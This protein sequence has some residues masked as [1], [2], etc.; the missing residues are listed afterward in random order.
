MRRKLR[1]ALRRL[2]TMANLFENLVEV[3][4]D[5][6]VLSLG[7]SLDYRLFPS[8]ILT[9]RDCVLFTNLAAEALIRELD[10]KKGERALTIIPN[11]GEF[12]LLSMAV[13]KA[14]GIIVP[15]DH[16]LP[17]DE[18]RRRA[19]GCWAGLAVIDGRVLAE[20]PD[21]AESMPAVERLMVSGPRRQAPGGFPS[22]DEAMG[23]SSGFFIP[24][25]LKPG[26]V[27]GLFYSSGRN[28][29]PRAVMATNEMLLG[30]RRT[31]GL[32]LPAGPGDRC[33]CALPPTSLPGF[34][35]AV[36]G[37]C[38]GLRFYLLPDGD[39]ERILRALQES[40]P[41][42]F[43]ASPVLY[44]GMLEAGADGYDLSPVRLWFGAGG[45]VHPGDIDAFRRLGSL[46]LGP[47]RLPAVFAEA[48]GVE[49][50]APMAA[51][52]LALSGAVRTA[53]RPCF[54]LPPNRM[55][56]VDETGRGVQ[57]GEEGELLLKGP[58]VTPGYWNDLEETFRDIRDGWLHTG[59]GA[60][61]VRY[62]VTDMGSGL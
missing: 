15:L 31:A 30:A 16:R 28:G 2:L 35:A 40:K 12:L 9:Y 59:T 5:R 1:L 50:S 62:G 55:K 48:C 34:S 27:V 57:R 21:L 41:T 45:S 19:E 26:N 13:I 23:E 60:R 25:T 42:V 7:N 11:P 51:L 4:G 6:E 10:L 29:S 24:Y 36:L 20:R 56:V 43:V 44:A 49:E 61:K 39:P 8:R 58:G 17:E 38:M 18:I 46:R 33:A 3:Y 54:P 32:L 52:R 22:L 47:L 14:G 37:L 53:A